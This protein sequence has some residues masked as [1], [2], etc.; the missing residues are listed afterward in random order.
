[1][2]HIGLRLSWLVIILLFISFQLQAQQEKC[3]TVSL[4]QGKSKERF[5]QWM[6]NMQ[7][8]R[9]LSPQAK[10]QSEDAEP[11]YRIPVVVHVV[12]L[13]ESEG[14]GSNIPFEQIADQIRILNE[15]FR[16]LNTDT[17]ETPVEFQPV[18]ADTRIEFVLARQSPE[19]F[20]TNGVVRVVGDRDDYGLLDGDALATLSQW[21]PELY[22]NIWVAPL[23]NNLLGYAQFPD[24]ELPGLSGAFTGPDTDG[25]VID[26]NFFGS[27]GNVVTRSLG[28]TTTHEV[29]HYLGLRHIWGDGDCSADDFVADTPLQESDSDTC[30]AHPQTSCSSVDMFQNYMDYTTDRCMN[31]FTLG[32]KARMRIVLENSPRRRTLLNS[33]GLAEPIVLDDDAGISAINSPQR[34][35]CN[36]DIVPTITVV[37]TGQEPLTSFAV[38]LNV[39]GNFREETIFNTNLETGEST[40]ASLS[41]VSLE[42]NAANAEYTFTFF[43]TEANGA[44]D[45]NATN[46]VSSINFIIPQRT[47]LPLADDFEQLDENSLLSVGYISNSDNGITWERTSVPG[48]SGEENEALEL[49]FFDYQRNIGAQDIFYTPVFSLADL[50]DASLSLRYAYAP[51]RDEDGS[52]SDDGFAIGIS[53]DCGATFDTFLFEASGEELATTEPTGSEFIPES[54]VDWRQLTFSLEAYAGNENLQLAFIGYNDYGNH[55]YI[56]DISIQA[57]QV[58]EIDLAISDIISPAY[59]SG[60]TNPTPKVAIKNIGRSSVRSFD[61]TYQFDSQPPTEFSYAAFVLAPGEETVL[62]LESPTLAPGIHNFSIRVINPNLR[63]DDV[64]NNNYRQI[65]FVVDDKEDIIPLINEFQE[66]SVPDVLQGESVAATEVWQVVNPDSSI[67]WETVEAGGNG[68]NNE[69]VGIQN[70]QYANIGA[71]DRL[72]SPS[73]DFS[74]TFEASLFFQVSYAQF[75]ENYVDT[76]NVLVSTDDGESYERVLEL[77][78]ITLSAGLTFSSEWIPRQD[79]DWHE[80]FVDLSRFAGEPKVRVAFESINGYGN[81]IFLDDIEFFLSGNDD[82]VRTAENSYRLFPNPTPDILNSV[83]NL[84]SRENIQA[85]IYNSQGQTV[86]QKSYPNTLNQTFNVDLS[87]FPRGIYIFRVFSSTLTD[88]KQFILQ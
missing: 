54:R 48:F 32:Q 67:T 56:D 38:A 23:R 63:V 21:D 34:S 22:M 86:W 60:Q 88:S 79:N 45:E 61:V 52:L 43:I 11:V 65:N 77:E 6:N 68:F 46:N 16:R 27:V 85:A 76:L 69:A 78:G 26:F 10:F 47:A 33:P 1:M 73:L 82:P 24:S 14:T 49:N 2:N 50:R 29:G 7:L 12:H 36:G 84:R 57:T 37:N 13:G 31:L 28:R 25:I 81:N 70:N 20:A 51:Y 87:T 58:R 53:T 40:T 66:Y 18:A 44:A 39:Q 17:T 5:E 8:K 4:N 42:G 3:G 72:V 80:M 55:L 64:P 62:E 83:F 41:S 9:Q 19:G 75:S 71:V 59:L 74:N 15:D 30:P 35:E